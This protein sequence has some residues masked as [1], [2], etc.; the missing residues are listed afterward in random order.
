VIA[1]HNNYWLWGPKAFDGSVVIVL[2]GDVTP[3]MKNYRSITQVGRI[4]S[5]YAQ[6]WEAHMPIY[7]L[8]GPRHP[9]GVLWPQL[10]YYE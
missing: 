5:P 7:V 2:D 1:G 8:R 4:D 6:S 10:R 3:L 9:L